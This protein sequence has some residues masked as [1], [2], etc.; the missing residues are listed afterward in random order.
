MG[1][2]S[3]GPFRREDSFLAPQGGKT[4]RNHMGEWEGGNLMGK[5]GG[6]REVRWG[7]GG[8]SHPAGEEIYVCFYR[9]GLCGRATEVTLTAEEF[10]GP[11]WTRTQ[12]ERE[13]AHS[14]MTLAGKRR[15]VERIQV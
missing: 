5:I 7:G 3:L 14:V 15:K 11:A 13:P 8:G 1:N 6:G 10:C 4:S 2:E 12:E 9:V